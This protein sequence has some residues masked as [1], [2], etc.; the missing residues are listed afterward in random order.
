[1]KMK[2]AK[3]AVAHLLACVAILSSCAVG[4]TQAGDTSAAPTGGISAAKSRQALGSQG[5]VAAYDFDEGSGLNAADASGHFNDGTL[6]QDMWST[7]GKHGGAAAFDG[8]Q[9]IAVEP[10]A[11][12][13]LT[14]AMTLEAWV[15][16]APTM[17]PF[18]AIFMKESETGLSYGLYASDSTGEPGEAVR[19][20][21]WI[22]T[23]SELRPVAADAPLA[24]ETWTHLAASYDNEALT[25]Y[26]D[27]AA[28]AATA[29]PGPIDTSTGVLSIGGG[30]YWGG[31]YFAGLIDDIRIYNR[32]LT[33][34]EI[35]ADMATPAGD[36][37]EGCVGLTVDDGNPCTLDACS[38]Q[39]GVTHT[40]LA[41]GTECNDSNACTQTDTCQ[42]GL[43]TPGALATCL[44]QDQCHTAGTCDTATGACSNP[45]KPD[46]SG[47]NDGNGCTQV[48]QCQAGLC[49]GSSAVVCVAQDQCH[50]VG[51]CDPTSGSC[52]NPAKPDGTTCSD[53]T[54]CTAGDSCQG[55]ACAAG[56]AVS[57][58]DNNPCTTDSCD[59]VS[60]VVHAV[61]AA[62]TSCADSTACNGA[63]VCDGAGQCQPGTPLTID[64]GN[65][66]T[67]DACDAILGVTHLPV[68]AGTGCADGDACNG[69][70]TCNGSGQCAQ[71]G[72]TPV[73]DLNPC[74][75]DACDPTAGVTHAPVA[76][77]LSCSDGQICNG[78]ERCDA[79]G[80]CG[81][82][83]APQLDD[84]DPCTV[85]LCDPVAGVQHNAIPGCGGVATGRPF[86]TRASI[87]GRVVRAD[88][89]TVTGFTV[90]V[91]NDK[92]DSTPRTD[93][94]TT[95]NSDG[96]FRT[97]LLEF[98]ESSAE[99]APPQHV[100][101][102]IESADFPFLLR[103]GYLR[104]G[105][106]LALGDLTVLQRDPSVT[107]IGPEGG[108]AEDS[109][110]TLQLVVPAGALA[111]PTPIRLTP[112]RSRAEFPL[113]LPS[114]TLTTYGMELEP[115]GT[116][117]AIPA[118]L[119]IKNTL[120]IPTTMRIPY[121][122]L[123]PHSGDW[124]SGGQAVWD[125]TR[126]AVPIRH[127]SPGDANG[128]RMGELV[129]VVDRAQADPQKSKDKDCV[130]SSVGYSNGSLQQSFEL[131]MHAASGRDHSLTLNYDSGLSGS[132]TVGTATTSTPIAGSNLR[133]S[134]LGLSVRV[135]CAPPGGAAASGCGGGGP[136]C[137][138]GAGFG[139]VAAPFSLNQHL[140]VFDQQAT[141]SVSLD[142][143]TDQHGAAFTFELPNDPSG[144]PVRSGYFPT[145]I[146]ASV[147][148]AG[149]KACAAGGAGFG[150]AAPAPLAS[151]G[152]ASGSLARLP[153]GEGTLLDFP[154]Y[155]LVIH[156][157]GS[158]L[159]SGWSLAEFG[160]LYRTPDRMAAELVKGDGESESFRPYP[161]LNQ[162]VN[163]GNTGGGS[164]AVDRQ[165]GEV[166]VV[167]SGAGSIS[168][169]NLTTGGRTPVVPTPV[170]AFG[171]VNL[172]VTYV[173]GEQRFLVGS[174]PGL[175]EVEANGTTRQLAAFAAGP[176]SRFPGAAGLGKYAYFTADKSGSGADVQ[177][178]G[179]IDLTDPARAIINI[180]AST[181]G[182][183]SLDP[184]GL[185]K[186]KDFW[187]IH[188]RGLTA[189]YDGGLYVADDRRHAVYH[190]APDANGEVGPESAVTRVLGSGVDTTIIGL[191]RKLPALEMPIR[192]PEAL[193]TAPDGTVY[194]TTSHATANPGAVLAFDPVER[195]AHWVAF[196]GDSALRNV[197]ISVR[198]GSLAPLGGD[199]IVVPHYDS[200][201]LLQAPFTSEFDP[202]RS[203]TFS[204]I[205]AT[206]V[207]ATADKIEQYRWTTPAANE[208]QLIGEQLRS[209]ETIRS[210]AYLDSDRV[211]YVQ[212]A[213][214]GRVTFGY[215]G[216]GR[217][218]TITDAAGRVTHL[219]VDVQGNLKEVLHPT[220]EALRFDYQDFRL[221][222]VT[223][224]DGE[225]STYTYAPD[226]TLQSAQ[227]P[228]GGT[229]LIQSAQSRGP[230]HDATGKLFYEA[231]VTDDRGV[232]HAIRVDAAG[233][234]ISDQFT[235][236]GQ[237]YN[238][239][240][241]HA[242]RLVG[243]TLFEST[244]NRLLRV[245]HTRVNGLPVTPQAT[246]NPAGQLIDLESSSRIVAPSYDAFKRLTKLDWGIT[247]IDWAYSYDAA[248]HLTKIADRVYDG[249]ETGRRTVFDGFRSTDG[250]PTSVIQH[251]VTTAIGYDALGLVNSS[252][253]STGRST[254]VTHDAAGNPI[255]VNDG[256]TTVNYGYDNGGRL[257]S[258][259]D[260]AGHVT[261]LDYRN[262]NCGCS[263]GDRLTS[264]VTP[265]LQANQRWSFDYDADGN[266]KTITNP[267]NQQEL[268][269]HN[270]Q[271]DL[272]AVVDRAGRSTTFVYDQLGRQLGITDPSGR[273]GTFAY[274]T[275][276]ATAWSGPT[277][278]ARSAGS[279]AAPTTLSAVLADGEYQ[280]GVSALRSSGSKDHVSLYRDA[281]F[282]LAYWNEYDALDRLSSRTDRTGLP[283]DS[284]VAGPS[285]ASGPLESQFDDYGNYGSPWA[286][287]LGRHV[288][289][290][291]S[292][293]T[294]S[295]EINRN[296]NFDITLIDLF[297]GLPSGDG[298]R[299]DRVTI[300]RDV[301]GRIVGSLTR[302][303]VQTGFRDIAS[304][305]ISYKPNGQLDGITLTTPDY[306]RE[307]TGASCYCASQCSTTYRHCSANSQDCTSMGGTIPQGK[308]ATIRLSSVSMSQRFEY[309][310]RGLLSSVFLTAGQT[311]PSDTG[312][313][314]YS[315]DEVGRNT[316]LVYPDGHTRQQTFD[317]LGRL[318]SR[319]YAYS[320]G[321]PEHCYTAEYDVAGNPK[322]LVDPDMRQ[323]ITYDALDRVTEVRRY[324]PPSASQPAYIETYAYNA[325][326]GFSIYD[327]VALDDR[328][329]RLAGG[330][331]ASAGI[332]AT[333]A[334]QP[335]TLDAGGRV[336]ALNG[337][338]FQY[339]KLNHRLQTA[340]TATERTSYAYDSL[341][342]LVGMETGATDGSLPLS[343]HLFIYNALE[344]S[345]AAI[346][347]AVRSAPTP[348]TSPAPDPP[349]PRTAQRFIY[350]GLD[351][352]LALPEANSRTVYYEVDVIGNVR[353]LH[354]TAEGV[355]ARDLGGYTY[356][357][358]GKSIP[359]GQPGGLPGPSKNQSLRWQ[360]RPQLG[361]NLYDF[362][363]RVW[364]T[365]LGAFLQPDEYGFLT[366]S[367]TLWSWPGQNPYRWRDPSGR[368]ASGAAAAAGFSAA[369]LAFSGWAAY[370]LGYFA[371]GPVVFAQQDAS[372]NAIAKAA[373][374]AREN[375]G[376]PNPG[377]RCK[378]DAS[379]GSGKAPPA[380]K[381]GVEA[382]S[383][384]PK[385]P[386]KALDALRHI[387]QTRTA[388]PGTR[389]GK[390]FANDGRGNG[391]I[392]PEKAP[393]GTPIR[394]QE[395]DVNKWQPGVN[396]G[397]ERL[398]TGSDGSAYYTSN[399][400]RSF[401]KVP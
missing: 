267:L 158:S 394:Y 86:E 76:A 338:T 378:T 204:P 249:G 375:Q 210:I 91:F 118:T 106:V 272:E 302:A 291:T 380:G 372:L 306:A 333:F 195:T 224:P 164:V 183:L 185:V 190:L 242:S 209:G 127:F 45:V 244:T 191:G 261:T 251:G 140:R 41:N 66:C 84:N 33:S 388:P 351:H 248:G 23:G 222:S 259:I 67:A 43:C 125:G 73:D 145:L 322:V 168:K 396:R 284:I 47:C 246:F 321:S 271:G 262:A 343:Q 275:P 298:T 102:R 12:L 29:T 238:V 167:W 217:I 390:D 334:G 189:A 123:D 187:F 292:N 273:V 386:R 301:A 315:Y 348:S 226:G 202:T 60:G 152:I 274:S 36:T 198:G 78:E 156:R 399:H 340:S 295:G 171:L 133:R 392:L 229:T 82:G 374:Q 87:M 206:I 177:T 309:D 88:G 122:T 277:L 347:E 247:G 303:I 400:Y 184:R 221:T 166:F 110:N 44:A 282:Q 192:G 16:P 270:P 193:T 59:S 4:C 132:V 395:W 94:V 264:I 63:E 9:W 143:N 387:Q 146:S 169:L 243:P 93:V 141:S 320:D 266:L 175:F 153:L 227:R 180:T 199:R 288:P 92:L 19:P 294:W 179:R 8:T 50:D 318:T 346:A 241:V 129:T 276:T 373:A 186:A 208:A 62:G 237:S 356:T 211:D 203:L 69:I 11:S 207:D 134:L 360:G 182:D 150:L 90:V 130:G 215:N 335:V 55:G 17:D 384:D 137:T 359:V 363:A 197:D 305:G 49:V 314:R 253:D 290:G 329:P 173:N 307:F 228:G 104:P 231:Q 325:L 214:G 265:D 3:G 68:A 144:A 126:F 21:V 367:G 339:Y 32:V 216:A 355:D 313:F 178:L 154:N 311:I 6:H 22:T 51:T 239:E 357:A 250:Q 233:S 120:N 236:G 330:G 35:M 278:F 149:S 331:T 165:T 368:F 366:P 304:S 61:V 397:A 136:A 196:D 109:Q 15:M 376:K 200:V 52:S 147:T 263:N 240:N 131:A 95:V 83:T 201:F 2:N 114:N 299:M 327:G 382:D 383:P 212:D 286:L 117:F 46:G 316:L 112:I 379:G 75:V 181:G 160:T 269:A 362:R 42:Q 260:A 354:G 97:R 213:A 96:T 377:T 39:G 79:V 30:T 142:P 389:G 115:S 80:V 353:H 105:D 113:P 323:E 341:E 349:N 280:V 155:E 254:S 281:T 14:T 10:S 225:L 161:L 358:F 232:Q 256:T 268:Y 297:L 34:A 119:R 350:D 257:T 56:T 235:A 289:D 74:T 252:V 25:I 54:V 285:Y 148:V 128:A 300:E 157:R 70:E 370:S 218:E 159:G 107:V 13:D 103:K 230:R 101:V 319:C 172:V 194:V 312:E 223:H 40:P 328:R 170:G 326:G 344:S 174:R 116:Q 245:S 100:L 24:P 364:S 58:D 151:G 205:G 138:I 18:S 5:L 124:E 77:G 220:G 283:F 332:P 369:E 64:D 89:T 317:A 28:V 381:G 352:P 65:S 26:I 135:E 188:P 234:V 385:I 20:F 72:A 108:V 336:T 139:V 27:G 361:P 7:S 371:I 310:T 176:T 99:R 53:G 398:V 324:V 293:R 57:L 48:D 255:V 391:E 121:G 401:T 163:M 85:D 71:S 296:P 258:V 337:K 219:T 38:P 31:E 342:R 81:I 37:S 393:D 98:P 162:I 111:A 287:L 1:M 365:E 308:C 345:A 279:T